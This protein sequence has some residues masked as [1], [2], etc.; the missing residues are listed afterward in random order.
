[1]SMLND[2]DCKFGKL[3]GRLLRQENLSQAEARAAFTLVL[4]NGPTEMQQG[5]FL[6]AL[7]A[8]GETAAEVAGAAGRPTERSPRL[9]WFVEK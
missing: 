2:C 5:A 9:R 1:M 3:I 7:A 8:K 4:R 6:A